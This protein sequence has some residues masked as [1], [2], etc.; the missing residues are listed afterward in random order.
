V[1]D[2]VLAGPQRGNAPARTSAS[3]E[4]A[5][6]RRDDTTPDQRRF[7]ASRGPDDSDEPRRSEAPEKIVDLRLAAEEEMVLVGFERSKARKR[8]KQGG[9]P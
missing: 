1:T 8:V 9:L 4:A 5:L 2:W 6:E 3:H 7:A